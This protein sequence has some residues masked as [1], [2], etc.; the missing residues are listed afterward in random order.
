MARFRGKTYWAYSIGCAM[1]WAV[2]LA[3]FLTLWA[4]ETRPLLLGMF[5][6]WI[7]WVSTTISRYA[8]PP[9]KRWMA[10]PSQTVNPFRTYWV[11]SGS[12]VIAWAVMLTL[13]R[14]IIGGLVAQ[15]LV[16]VF[17]GFCLGW[18]STT[19]ARYGYPPPKR[20]TSNERHAPTA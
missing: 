8:F 4:S 20:W 18:F 14:T 12:L 19:I 3:I 9:P 10:N 15:T 13:A 16:F 17:D 2:V 1:V 5:G 7:C 11:Y 6:W